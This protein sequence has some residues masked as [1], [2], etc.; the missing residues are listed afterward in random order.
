MSPD[1]GAISAMDVHDL[2][3]PVANHFFTSNGRPNGAWGRGGPAKTP[4]GIVT[5]TA[6]GPYDP[7]SGMWGSS[8][9][10][11]TPKVAKLLEFLHAV[12]LE[13]RE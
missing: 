13:I 4:S 9:L 7:A 11:F 12:K 3:H 8:V 10:E 1:P 2:A 5:Q 6:D